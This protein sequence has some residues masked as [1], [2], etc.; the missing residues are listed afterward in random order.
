MGVTER[1]D[2]ISVL[3][4][5]E[6]C[7]FDHMLARLAGKAIHHVEVETGDAGRAQKSNGGCDLVF[8]LDPVDPLLNGRVQYLNAKAG[9]GK[10]AGRKCLDD[11]E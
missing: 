4:C 8:G 9:A 11:L 7:C 5:N 2:T 6:R 10:A 3:R 1:R